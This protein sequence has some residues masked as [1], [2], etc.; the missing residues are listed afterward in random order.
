M[1]LRLDNEAAVWEAAQ[2]QTLPS[3]RGSTSDEEDSDESDSSDDFGAR[4]SN[5]RAKRQRGRKGNNAA[6]QSAVPRPEGALPQK[7]SFCWAC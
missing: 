3:F 7:A 4:G 1:S 5:K 6:F 2:Q